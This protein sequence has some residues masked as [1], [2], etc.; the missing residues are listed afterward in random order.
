MVVHMHIL[1]VRSQRSLQK[2][3]IQSYRWSKSLDLE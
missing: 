3:M 1:S 2:V